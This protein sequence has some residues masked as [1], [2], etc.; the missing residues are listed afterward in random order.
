M[1]AGHGPSITGDVGYIVNAG[2]RPRGFSDF[3]ARVV[4]K[5][6][7]LAYTPQSQVQAAGTADGVNLLGCR[8]LT[9][10]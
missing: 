4:G 1:Q 2:T 3:T 10:V 9:G 7:S 5:S 8:R 6:G